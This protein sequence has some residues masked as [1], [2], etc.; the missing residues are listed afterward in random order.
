MRR[1]LFAGNWKMYTNTREAGE[2]AAGVRKQ[3]GE[4][5]AVDVV[6]C[7]PF[8]YLADVVDVVR[9]SRIGVG[10]QNTHW[11]AQ[12]AFT[13]EIAP[14]MLKD[15]GC[16]YVIIGHSER[17]HGLGETDQL[18]HKKTAAALAAGLTP[19]VC[20]GELLEEREQGKTNSVLERQVHGF[21]KGLPSESLGRIVIAY[22]PVWAIGT[23]KTAT[24]AQAQEAHIFIRKEAAKATTPAVAAGMRILY[25]GSVKPDNA[26]ELK[27]QPDVDGA[28]VGGASLKADS[29]AAIARAAIK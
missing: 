14:A 17:R 11:E 7:P 13:G 16:T 27:S 29:F 20:V 23:G 1:P 19:I 26:K 24:P 9:G 15:I 5:D 3:L 21:L 22:E 25:G 4:L 28:L 8:V 10:A 12:G 18:V 2:L 6:L